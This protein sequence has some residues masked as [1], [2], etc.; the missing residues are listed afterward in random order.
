MFVVGVCETTL[1]TR[2]PV[3][4]VATVGRR[5]VYSLPEIEELARNG[6]VLVIMFRQALNLRHEPITLQELIA[7]GVLSSHPQAVSKTRP[8]GTPWLAQRLDE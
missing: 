1:R 7:G 4:I 5:T 6:E 2:D 8:G 3:E